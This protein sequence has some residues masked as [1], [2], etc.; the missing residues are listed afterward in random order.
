MTDEGDWEEY[1][2]LGPRGTEF[3]ETANKPLSNA[4]HAPIS[5]QYAAQLTDYCTREVMAVLPT[6]SDRHKSHELVKIMQSVVEKRFPD[7]GL[8]VCLFGSAGS[9]LEVRGS[10]VDICLRSSKWKPV[11]KEELFGFVNRLKNAIRPH[12]MTVTQTVLRSKSPLLKIW[13]D[14]LK[15]HCDLTLPFDS[16]Y[17]LENTN[18]IRSYCDIDPRV[19]P[20]ITMIKT[21]AKRRF[22][23]NAATDG[24]LNSYSLV[25]MIIA[26]LQMLRQPILP[27]LQQEK[28]TRIRTYKENGKDIELSYC[29]KIGPFKERARLNKMSIG[30]LLYG[31]FAFYSEV[32]TPDGHRYDQHILSIRTGTALDKFSIGSVYKS[33]DGRRMDKSM[34]RPLVIEEPFMQWNTAAAVS[35]YGMKWVLSEFNRAYRMLRFEELPERIFSTRW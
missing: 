9:Q 6:E 10:D 26:Y 25:L 27:V 15:L 31:W 18:L 35:E 14:Q 3:L 12:G 28:P 24:T 20:L 22:I 5:Y 13:I 11:D 1:I 8:V 2:V 33:V 29:D 16:G 17:A 32:R 23:N 34:S 21:F 30:E 19:R 4:P 7:Y